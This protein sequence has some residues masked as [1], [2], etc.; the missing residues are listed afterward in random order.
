MVFYNQVYD[1]QKQVNCCQKNPNVV[2]Y[3]GT[4][5]KWKN[6]DRKRALFEFGMTQINGTIKDPVAV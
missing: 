1:A 6:S 5:D 2:F 3:I 4:N